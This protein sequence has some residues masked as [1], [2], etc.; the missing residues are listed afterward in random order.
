MPNI[1]YSLYHTIKSIVERLIHPV[2][3]TA[4]TAL[5]T[6]NTA[7]TSLPRYE[8]GNDNIALEI[9]GAFREYSFI[10]L[11]TNIP[12]TKIL[13]WATIDILDNAAGSGSVVEYRLV[14]TPTGQPAQYGSVRRVNIPHGHRINVSAMAHGTGHTT[15]GNVKIH[16]EIKENSGSA[17]YII[18][19]L[20]A[21]ANPINA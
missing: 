5:S 10:T 1:A 15:A 9:T 4:D 2:K 3:S 20:I 6:A 12:S 7:I 13:V 19:E 18:S 8:Y 14:I 16:L 21:V 17:R 11:T